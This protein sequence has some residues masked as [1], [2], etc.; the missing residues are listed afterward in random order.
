MEMEAA[1]DQQL[2]DPIDHL[3]IGHSVKRRGVAFLLQKISHGEHFMRIGFRLTERLM[4]GEA[5]AQ[6]R[7]P[8]RIAALAVVTE[9]PAGKAEPRHLLFRPFYPGVSR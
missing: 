7:L 8:S 6:T 9:L 3:I 1:G 4:S 2:G 5:I